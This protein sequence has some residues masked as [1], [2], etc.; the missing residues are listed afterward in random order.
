MYF[1]TLAQETGSCSSPK[2]SRKFTEIF[3][4]T[5]ASITSGAVLQV[6]S[7]EKGVSER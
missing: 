1:S 6:A 3:F 5:S 7:F 4:F 2:I